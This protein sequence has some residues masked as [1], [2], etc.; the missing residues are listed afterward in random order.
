MLSQMGRDRPPHLRRNVA[1]RMALPALSSLLYGPRWLFLY[2]GI[3]LFLFGVCIS[4]WLLPGQRAIG[5]LIFDYHTLLF[6][7]MAILV[8]FQ[9]INFAAFSKIFATAEG[10]LPE[11]PLLN[12]LYRY[13]TL[14]VG[15]IVGALLV[16]VGS[17]MWVL[18]TQLLEGHS[19][20]ATGPGENAKNRDPRIRFADFGDTDYAFG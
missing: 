5:R 3:A 6:G 4:A 19:F 12:R 1:R 18:G 20:W 16:L 2:P 11:D 9:S 8:G 10:L 7:A 14:E 15:L 13:I 17:S